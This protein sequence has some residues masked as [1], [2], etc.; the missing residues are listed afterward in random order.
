MF[1]LR[2]TGVHIYAVVPVD[3][4]V[5]D[6]QAEFYDAL[7][8]SAQD[9]YPFGMEM[10]G[11]T[12]VLGG[13][14]RY[15]FNG[16]EK[17]ASEFGSL[18]VYDYGFRIYN[19]AIAKFLSVDPLKKEYPELTPYQFA[20]NTPIQAIDLDGLEMEK[21]T[22]AK[23]IVITA[24]I[25]N[26]SKELATK[27]QKEAII[28]KI[29]EGIKAQAEATLAGPDVNGDIWTVE[30]NL[31][32]VADPATVTNQDVL[33]E[34]G[35]IIIDLR[36]KKTKVNPLTG[37]HSTA[38]GQAEI[39]TPSH[40]R[41]FLVYAKEIENTD[42]SKET[43][44]K[45]ISEMSRSAV[46]E[47]SHKG[48]LP[49][50]WEDVGTVPDMQQNDP[51]NDTKDASKGAIKANIMNSDANPRWSRANVS[52]TE[53]TPGQRTEILSNLPEKTDKP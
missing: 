9:Y 2:H 13:G 22:A 51:P 28:M 43:E 32:Y 41:V 12:F 19:P 23:K 26:Y 10:P 31:V 50:P 1:S 48:G 33:R 3:G 15:G 17:D 14:Y 45:K 39:N 20:S 46:H 35:T 36:D 52:G 25:V 53:M 34:D 24:T 47:L 7:V 18:A 4:A 8:L 16:K 49:H 29:G 38:E 30:V 42:G 40:G 21:S 27:K 44:I 11:R 6:N 37:E 5:A